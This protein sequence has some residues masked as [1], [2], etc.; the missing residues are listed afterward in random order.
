[1]ALPIATPMPQRRGD[2]FAVME[3]KLK[4]LFFDQFKAKSSTVE[5]LAHTT[6]R[7]LTTAFTA[8]VNSKGASQ[9]SVLT[10]SN[11]SSTPH[12]VSA[13]FSKIVFLLHQRRRLRRQ[14][15]SS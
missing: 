10:P 12:V 3:A 7:H 13:C 14:Q 6:R 8:A 4:T 9:S 1:M 15:Q 11:N 2:G 5:G